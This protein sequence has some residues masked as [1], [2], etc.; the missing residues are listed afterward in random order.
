MNKQV[1]GFYDLADEYYISAITLYTQIADAP[2]LYNP[3][4]Y[5]LRHT[6]EL[7]LK[8]LIVSEIRKDNKQLVINDIRLDSVKLCHT[9]SLLLLW[10]HY[11]IVLSTHGIILE[12]NTKSFISKVI[13]K[14]DNKDFSSTR[15][16]YPIDKNENSIDLN[17]VKIH[18]DNISPDL[19]LGIPTII[20]QGDNLSIVDKGQKLLKD[21]NN[22]I[23]VTDLLFNLYEK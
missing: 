6:I 22:L 13:K 1:K 3:I 7:V 10:K 17:P 15:Y 4:S 18:A 5:L 19:A 8:G 9:H 23:E 2:Y 11:N 14:I 12:R 20:Q 21:I 16:R